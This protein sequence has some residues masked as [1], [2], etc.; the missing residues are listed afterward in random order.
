MEIIGKKATI[1]RK[2]SS[3]NLI[4]LIVDETKNTIKLKEN[5]SG[6]IRTLL[7]N[8]IKIKINNTKI[9]GK[10]IMQKPEERL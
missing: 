9:N 6:K 7:K 1:E 4:G 10:D 3:I 5:E 2:N 8:T